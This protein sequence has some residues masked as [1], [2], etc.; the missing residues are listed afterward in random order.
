M[1]T[2]NQIHE[3]QLERINEARRV[4]DKPEI[5]E[6]PEVTWRGLLTAALS[7]R[8]ME[9]VSDGAM[10]LRSPVDAERLGEL[11][12]TVVEDRGGHEWSVQL[13]ADLAEIEAEYWANEEA[14]EIARLEALMNETDHLDE[15]HLVGVL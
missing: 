8:P 13:S 10:F 3:A 15:P 9:R 5:T 4:M 2:T 12:G 14:A 1:A 6:L 7:L 11:W